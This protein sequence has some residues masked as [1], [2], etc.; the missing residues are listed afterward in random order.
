LG[1]RQLPESGP[2]KLVTRKRCISE[3]AAGLRLLGGACVAALFGA[4]C[5]ACSGAPTGAPVTTYKQAYTAYYGTPPEPAVTFNFVQV[6]NF[7]AS[8]ESKLTLTIINVWSSGE[9]LCFDYSGSI[10]DGSR[11]SRISGLVGALVPG[12]GASTPENPVPFTISSANIEIT[13][14]PNPGSTSIFCS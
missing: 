1:D 3:V 13:L 12:Q 6:F 9:S 8:P 7:G 10:T 4:T 2:A 5:V 14:S 11:S